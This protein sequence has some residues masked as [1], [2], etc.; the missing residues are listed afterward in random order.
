MKRIFMVIGNEMILP[1]AYFP[2]K[3]MKNIGPGGGIS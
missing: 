1:E 2:P 3:K